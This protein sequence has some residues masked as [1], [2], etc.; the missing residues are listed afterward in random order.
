MNYES[1]FSLLNASVLPAW[2]LL[3][4]CPT[5]HIT[6]SFVHSG[7]YALALGVFY[8]VAFGFAIVGGHAEGADF[9]TTAGI[10]LLFQ[11]PNGVLVGWCHYLVFDLFVGAWI[12]RDS[13]RRNLPHW[14]VVPCQLLTF[15]LG[16]IGLLS[17]MLLRLA[18]GKGTSLI[19][20][21]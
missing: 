8:V 12:G 19:E 3:V 9:T 11:H 20:T 15:I 14:L 7:I 18:T 13:M 10:S 21:T 5:A 16:P 2:L 1:V 4:F 6:K 17:Y